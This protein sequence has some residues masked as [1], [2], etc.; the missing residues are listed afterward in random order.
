MHVVDVVSAA[1]AFLANL[2]AG[3]T[4]GPRSIDI[5][6]DVGRCDV[7]SQSALDSEAA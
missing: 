2:C 7:R 3:H 5:Q 4:G 1:D 6:R